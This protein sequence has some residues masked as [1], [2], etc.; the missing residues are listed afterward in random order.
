MSTTAAVTT[1]TSQKPSRMSSQDKWP[2]DG[3]VPNSNRPYDMWDHLVEEEEVE[4]EE[5]EEVAEGPPHACLE[6]QCH[7]QQ[8]SNL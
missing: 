8:M 3:S 4:E 6:H 2:K 7:Q 5:V 1:T